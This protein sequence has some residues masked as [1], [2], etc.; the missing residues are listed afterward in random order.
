MDTG[1][2]GWRRKRGHDIKTLLNY[3]NFKI[4]KIKLIYNYSYNL[5]DY[6]FRNHGFLNKLYLASTKV[7]TIPLLVPLRLPL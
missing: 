7:L 5:E 1:G 2:I 3:E 6:P 4:Y